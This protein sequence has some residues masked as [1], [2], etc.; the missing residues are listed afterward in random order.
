ME[1]FLPKPLTVAFVTASLF[2]FMIS[3]SR[4]LIGASQPEVSGPVSLS[5]V[6]NLIELVLHS[7]LL[8]RVLRSLIKLPDDCV[9]A[10]NVKIPF[11][12]RRCVQS[13]LRYANC[14]GLTRVG[15]TDK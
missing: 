6:L 13:C 11:A 2:V 7:L 3:W 12:I 5:R 8:I 10:N 15:N 4:S 9:I 1:T 14:M